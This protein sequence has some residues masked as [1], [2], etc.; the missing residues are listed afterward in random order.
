MRGE[1]AWECLKPTATGITTVRGSSLRGL[2]VQ[3]VLK[4]VSAVWEWAGAGRGRSASSK[5]AYSHSTMRGR[6]G[7]QAAMWHKL[8][9][10]LYYVL[11]NN[12]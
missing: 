1:N 2:G 4:N 6:G 5:L 11:Y 7:L 8:L 12:E 9:L 3:P 10:P